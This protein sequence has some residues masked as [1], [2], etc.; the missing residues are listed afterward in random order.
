MASITRSMPL[1]GPSRPQVEQP[2]PSG[3]SARGRGP[4]G[5]AAPCGISDDLGGVD[6]EA[7]A[8]PVPPGLG[9]DDHFVGGV[10]DR[11][12][13][14]RWCGVGDFE[15]GVGDDDRRPDEPVEHV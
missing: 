15:H 3:R 7:A 12:E 5:T 14:R 4:A 13:N 11:L 1:P 2:G 9:H 6:V 8:Q 10:G